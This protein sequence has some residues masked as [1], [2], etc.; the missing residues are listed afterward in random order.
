MKRNVNEF[1]LF[2]C[3]PFMFVG[4]VVVTED[5][6]YHKVNFEQFKSLRTV[7]QK[8]GRLTQTQILFV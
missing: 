6:E 4:D 1:T 5:E 2:H 3:F 8:D 7:F